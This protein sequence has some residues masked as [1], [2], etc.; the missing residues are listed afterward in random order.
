[1]FQQFSGIN[2]IIYFTP[3]IIKEAKV[4]MLFSQL[5][6]KD[7]AASLL[8]TVL[9]YVPKIPALFTT[10]ALLDSCGRRR[11]L[12][13]FVPVMGLCHVSLAIAFG[14]MKSEAVNWFPRGL[15]LLGICG[16]GVSFALSIGPIPN[17][18]TAEGFPTRVRPTAM[19]V[20]L[21]SQF[22]F[23]T[24][25]GFGFPILRHRFGTQAVFAGFAGVCAL[26]WLFISRFV[27]ETKSESL[28]SLGQQLTQESET[29]DC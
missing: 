18:I 23:N 7:N 28:E 19:A 10:M 15:A 11:L 26:A 8:A 29:S 20:S 6:L 4:P 16:Y 21:G 2:A 17:I 24:L 22:F 14:M 27:P 3:Q 1:M 12:R 13:L 25:V 5:G 9:V